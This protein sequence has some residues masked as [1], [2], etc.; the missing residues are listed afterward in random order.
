M[1]HEDGVMVEEEPSS[2]FDT[3]TVLAATDGL[4]NSVKSFLA[5]PVLVEEFQWLSADDALNTKFNL[6]FPSSWFARPMIK[7]KISGFR[8]FRG[9]LVVRLQVNAQPFNAGRLLMYWEPFQKTQSA[10]PTSVQHFG[11]ITGYRH[12]DLDVAEATSAELRITYMSPLTH[13]DLVTGAGEMGNMVCKVYSKLTGGTSVEAS[14]WAHFENVSLEMPT[15]LPIHAYTSTHVDKF[16]RVQAH[17]GG[18]SQAKKTEP[19]KGDFQ[20]L[21]DSQKTVAD[22]FGDIPVIGEIFKGISWVT[23][24]A[25]GVAGIFGFS[26]PTNPD[27][28]TGVTPRYFRGFTNFNGQT[29]SKPLGLDARNSV[30]QPAGTFGTQDDEMA[31]AAILQKPVF[32]DHFQM[33][34]GDAPGKILW[35]WPVHPTS[36]VKS[37]DETRVVNLETYLSYLSH[38]FRFWRGGLTYIFKIVKTPYHSGR[39]RFV[40]VPG[41]TMTTDPTTI[42]RDKCYSQ[43]VDI[44]DVTEHS[45]N[46]PF[47][48]NRYW[49]RCDRVNNTYA[50]ISLRPPTGIV[51]CEV[52]NT[53]RNGGASA[54]N[55]EFLVETHAAKDFQFGYFSYDSAFTPARNVPGPPPT[56]IQ[57]HS[58]DFFPSRELAGVLPNAFTMGEAITS[59]RQVLKRVTRIGNAPFSASRWEYPVL[60]TYGAQPDTVFDVFSYVSQLYRMMS[61][62]MRLTFLPTAAGT[63]PIQT[64]S[65]LPEY[66][67]PTTDFW[68]RTFPWYVSSKFTNEQNG[69]PVAK[70]VPSQEGLIDVDVPWYQPAQATLTG[71][72]Q[73]YDISYYTTTP[74]VVPVNRGTRILYEPEVTTYVS[75]SIAEDF[76]FGYLIGVPLTV[77]IVDPPG[78]PPPPET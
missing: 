30:I 1:F 70:F 74:N 42:D 8:Y 51:I 35:K 7:E 14:V 17:S 22:K 13:I 24:I 34:T 44:R 59:L 54:P 60:D 27:F 12:I 31:L 43:V 20:T 72:G 56:K 57:A 77:W 40:F 66:P 9:D 39:V 19:K 71:V 52:L 6:N 48:S 32:M 11:G 63:I 21:F 29:L 5:R 68:T 28:E 75:R 26:K 55:I 61:G 46:V 36:C 58:G 76:S 47:V 62:G 69:N 15:G 37:P 45:F 53:L 64:I 41:G 23:D 78:S 18:V 16:Y 4:E 67:S 2:A 65:L 50:P 73:P 10:V 25:S 3:S 33:A 38:M 49:E